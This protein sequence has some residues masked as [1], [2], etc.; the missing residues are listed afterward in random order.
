LA[1]GDLIVAVDGRPVRLFSDFLS[2]IMANKSPGDK[3]LITYVRDGE[4]KEAPLTLGK[5][6]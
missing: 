2:Y 1:G 5:R 6:P 3:I 4:E